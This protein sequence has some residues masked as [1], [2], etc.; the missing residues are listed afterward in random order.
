MGILSINSFFNA[1]IIW[2]AGSRCFSFFKIKCVL[3]SNLDGNMLQLLLGPLSLKPYLIWFHVIK[4]LF[5]ELWLESNLRI[6]NNKGHLLWF[7]SFNS[8]CLKAFKKVKALWTNLIMTFFWNLWKER[9]QRVFMVKTQTLLGSSEILLSAPFFASYSH[10]SLIINWEG[11]LC[12]SWTTHQWNCLLSRKKIKILV[13]SFQIICSLFFSWHFT[14]IGMFIFLF[15]CFVVLCQI[16]T[17][18]WRLYLF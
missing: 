16:F 15:S 8:A 6:F 11:L 9:N 2:I 1:L 4:A 14:Y 10:T 13:H 18:K 5:Y 7:E 3:S 17:P 12:T